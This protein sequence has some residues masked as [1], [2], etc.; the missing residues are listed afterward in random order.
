[1]KA[2]LL[3]LSSMLVWAMGL[4]AANYLIG[5]VPPLPLTAARMAL[6]AAV[7]LP[8]W[9]VIEGRRALT[10]APWGRGIA[11]GWLMLGMAGVLLVIAQSRTDAVTVAVISASMP[12]LGIALECVLDGRRLTGRLVAGLVLSLTGGLLAYAEAMGS[13]RLGLGAAAA[14]GSILCY[15][16]GSRLTITVLPGLTPLGRTT[17]TLAGAAIACI[18]V[19]LVGHLADLP[20]VQWQALGPREAL[21]LAVFAILGLSL[22]QLL[23]I[24]SVGHLGIGQASLHMN[25]AP[26]YVMIF[27]WLL[28]A[29][30]NW[31]QALGAAIVGAGVLI[32]QSAP[33]AQSQPV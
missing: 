32:A 10:A 29:D 5:P 13:F 7:L 30:W 25:A 4:P 28:G 26:F 1:M 24:A 16:L 18:G 2:N 22:T 12:V 6:A 23:W 31:T 27:L 14:F 8:L 21:A 33:R 20:G 15:T 19:A 9:W 3:C 11:I 17:L